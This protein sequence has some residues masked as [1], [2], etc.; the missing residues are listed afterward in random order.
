MSSKKDES[1]K[2]KTF[3]EK[4]A[5]EAESDQPESEEALAHDPEPR[6]EFPS[7][8]KLEAELTALEQER[9]QYKGEA[10]R[11]KADLQ[12]ALRRAERDVSEAHKYGSKK[13]LEDLLPVLDGLERGLE[14]GTKED[15]MREGMEMV[16]SMLEKTLAK[17]GVEII[18][19]KPGEAFNADLHQ[20]MSMQSDPSAKPNTIISVMQRGFSL[21]GRVLRAAMVVVAAG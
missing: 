15:P 4:Q 20:A 6:L 12:N 3:S 19:P 5:K 21:N 14:N 1:N 16:L 9:D 8:D 2:W 7:H 13:L 18:D 10:L 17:H 11:A